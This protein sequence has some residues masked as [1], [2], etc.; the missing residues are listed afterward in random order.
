MKKSVCPVHNKRMKRTETKYGP[1]WDCKEPGCTV[2][3]WGGNTSTPAN[4]EL[5]ALRRKCHDHFDDLWRNRSPTRTKMYNRLS[6][7]MNLPLEDTHIGMFDIMQCN[8]VLEFVADYKRRYH[9]CS[10]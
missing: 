2:M 7:Y 8:K 1:R 9:Q 3:C 4:D 5:R 6:E 10:Q